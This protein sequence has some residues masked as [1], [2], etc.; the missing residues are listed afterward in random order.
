MMTKP[1]IVKAQTRASTKLKD[2]HLSK[3][4]TQ[5]RQLHADLPAMIKQLEAASRG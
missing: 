2:P 4:L 3:L 5:A 1:P